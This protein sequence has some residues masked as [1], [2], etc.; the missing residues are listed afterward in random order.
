MIPAPNLDDR[1]HADIVEE[2]IRL[3]P[4]YCPD[5]TNH[6]PTDPGITLIE[7]FAWMTEMIIYRLNKVTDKN[8]LAFL[9]LMGVNLQPPQPARAL[10]T[11]GLAEGAQETLVRAGT[12][13]ATAQAGEGEPLVFETLSDLLVLPN[14]IVKCYSQF[15]DTY[16]D[17]T[18]FVEGLRPRGFELF[19]GAR[20]IDRYIYLGD[21]RFSTLSESAI[22]YL[23]FS[24]PDSSEV[25]FPKLLEWEYWNGHRWRELQQAS[26]ETERNTIAFYGPPEVEA[27]TVNDTDEA[28]DPQFWVRGRLVEVP[29][30]LEDTVLDSVGARIEVL[31]EGVAPDDAYTNMEGS[32]FLTVDLSKNFHPLGS[33]PK[34]D[35]A[36]YIAAAELFSQPEATIR[37]ELLLSDPSVAEP[38]NPSKDL[39]IAWEYW[40]GKKWKE[41]GQATAE[42]PRLGELHDFDDT[43]KAFS[44]SGEVSFK[45]PADMQGCSVNSEESFWVRARVLTGNYG[46]PGTYELEGD[47]WIWRDERP[48]RPPTCK[49]LSLKYVEEDQTPS[50][51][52]IFND[53]Q[54][55]DVSA[56]ARQEY[57]YFQAFE[58]VAEESPSLYLGFDKPFPNDRIQVYFHVAERTALDVGAEFADELAEYY[59]QRVDA[60]A[61]EQRL[62][63]EYWQGREWKAFFPDDGT[64]N[65]TQ[66]GFISFIG[67]QDFRPVQRFGT[68]CFWVRCRLE[69]GGYDQMPR[70]SA[71]RL[72]SVEAA[73]L[74]TLREEVLGSSDGTPNQRFRFS[75]GPVLDGEEIWVREREEP[76]A[77]ERERVE[78]QAGEGS[79]VAAEGKDPGWWVHWTRVE[80]FFESD[81]EDRHYVKDVTTGEIRFSDGRRGMVPPE[82]D[83]NIKAARYRVGGGSHGNVGAY[84]VNTLRHPIAHIDNVTNP[85]PATGGADQESVEDAKLRGPHTIKSRNRAVTAEDFEWLSLQA[86]NSIARAKCLQSR[87]REGEVTVIIL[88]KI[89]DRQP[90]W[91][92][93]LIPSTELLRRVHLYLDTRRLVTALVNVVKPRYIEVSFR[94]EVIREPTQVGDRLKRDIELAIR[95]F[96]HPLAGGRQGHGWEFGRNVYKVDVYH[97]IEEVSGVEFVDRVDIYD[98]D[99]KVHVD[100]VRLKEDELVHV[101]DIDVTERARERI[102]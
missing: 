77:A 44:A 102:V 42:G 38:P 9:D 3:I 4:Q 101:V 52:L 25:N 94:I 22:L 27:T 99:R 17:N 83:R 70:I 24:T 50:N 7:L 76:T 14:S 57:T 11:F 93:K 80:S 87:E 89:D 33:E 64:R 29:T 35:Y 46:Q 92:K 20:T 54:F 13:V 40:N 90:D 55:S 36:L 51:L 61:A 23:T 75:R 82:G 100:H 15:H 71:I 21:A 66:S 84:T 97:V 32:V 81:P 58:P 49:T 37:I 10:L 2:A 65:F 47:R 53:F 91:T 96:L 73:N 86:S 95:R 39:V 16:S 28:E 12:Q 5:W 60:L 69:M 1:T 98:E 79:V 63:W 8:F 34:P 74:V 6:N 72:N 41:F 26:V 43:T 68:K 45:R 67:F 88:P 62:R 85:Y 48:L 19:M 78:A 31:G 18:P 30:H 56:K 59:S